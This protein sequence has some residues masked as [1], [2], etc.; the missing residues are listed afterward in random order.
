MWKER[1]LPLPYCFD[2][3][4]CKKLQALWRYLVIM[5]KSVSVSDGLKMTAIDTCLSGGAYLNLRRKKMKIHSVITIAAILLL[6]FTTICTASSAEAGAPVP[7]VTV[8]PAASADLKDADYGGGLFDSSVIHKIDIRIAS[9]DWTDLLDNAEKKTKYRAD[10]TIDGEKMENISCSAKGNSSLIMARDLYGN[11]RYSLKINF[12]RFNKKQKFHGLKKIN[13]NNNYG[14]TTCMKDFLCYTMFRKA[15]ADAPLCSYAWVTV[16]GRDHGLFLVVEEIDERFLERTGWENGV[17]YKPDSD[18]LKADGEDFRGVIKNGVQVVDY[19]EGAE[20][21][22]RGERIEDYPDIFN[23]AETK[24][25]SEA[26]LRVIKALKG[27]SSGKDFDKYLYTDELVHYFAV[28]SF[29]LN[30]DGYTGAF[31]HNYY[32]CEKDGRLAMFP[33]D[34]NLAFAAFWVHLSK[35]KTDAAMFVNLGIDTP[36][37]GA[38]PQQ[39]PMWKWIADNEAWRE[40]YHLAMDKFLSAYFESGE[41]ERQI[42]DLIEMLLPY[43]KKD[44]TSFYSAEQVISASKALRTFCLLRAESIRRQLDGKLSTKTQ[45]QSTGDKVNASMITIEELS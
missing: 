8:T 7:A 21:S 42:D 22:Y 33:W 37:L 40:K 27:L 15:G 41:F 14:D 23:N 12:G 44:P 16:N 11:G 25:D 26:M 18:K 13:L 29:V 17:L 36:V 3:A 4:V 35:E 30:H 2:V 1:L 38:E 24:A 5:K 45:E 28:Q 9:E 34:C 43:I 19:S 6:A 10:I 39:R 32:L 31:L 20:L